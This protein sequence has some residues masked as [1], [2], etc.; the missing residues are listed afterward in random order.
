VNSD[1]DVRRSLSALPA[2]DAAQVARAAP[3]VRIVIE[4]PSLTL[5]AFGVPVDK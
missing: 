5:A 2:H 3:V 4:S 1:A